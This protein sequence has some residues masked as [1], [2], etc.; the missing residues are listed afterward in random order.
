MSGQVSTSII[1]TSIDIHRH[2]D[3]PPISISFN[4]RRVSIYPMIWKSITML[5]ETCLS[6]FWSVDVLVCWRFGLSTFWFVDILV[7]RR[8]GLSTFRSV[9]VLVCRRFGLLTFWFVDVSVCRRFGCRRFGL[10]TF[11]PVTFANITWNQYWWFQFWRM[12]VKLRWRQWSRV[13]LSHL[14]GYPEP[15]SAVN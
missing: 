2:G 6:T 10:S 15:Y 7:C 12:W 1:S 11:W 4:L 14:S 13:C 3:G 9:D 8:F 5:Y